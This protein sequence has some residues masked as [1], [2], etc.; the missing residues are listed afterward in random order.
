[1]RPCCHQ[2][3][4]PKTIYSTIFRLVLFFPDGKTLLCIFDPGREGN[5]RSDKAPPGYPAS[6]S[7]CPR[8]KHSQ[9]LMRFQIFIATFI[10]S[11]SN[12]S[13]ESINDVTPRLPTISHSVCPTNTPSK[14][15]CSVVEH[16]TLAQTA[17]SQLHSTD[18][19]SYDV[20]MTRLASERKSRHHRQFE[21]RQKS[22]AL[23][24]TISQYP[25]RQMSRTHITKPI[26]IPCG[27]LF[28]LPPLFGGMFDPVALYVRRVANMYPVLV[29]LPPLSVLLIV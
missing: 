23:S 9:R 5:G 10:F 6:S 28:T 4:G 21:T 18:A 29:E 2:A 16:H 26:I 27:W 14:T 19:L 8:I 7:N 3:R 24:R 12:S 11:N 22:I 1:M 20:P 17:L 13:P 25:T 15:S